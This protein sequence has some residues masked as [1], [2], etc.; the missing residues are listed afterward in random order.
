MLQPDL[1][2][3][4]Q[5][6]PA[7]SRL[8]AT[9]VRI[10]RFSGQPPPCMPF[11]RG[12]SS[13]DSASTTARCG[14]EEAARSRFPPKSARQQT[15]IILDSGGKRSRHEHPRGR[16]ANRNDRKGSPKPSG[17]PSVR[18]RILLVSNLSCQFPSDSPSFR[19]DLTA[20]GG[21]EPGDGRSRVRRTAPEASATACRGAYLRHASTSRRSDNRL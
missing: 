13:V 11:G 2:E 6:L 5:R 14:R 19:S 21:G 16:V 4:H 18:R 8:G 15:D 1:R 9:A 20:E 17:G 12:R 10:H 7:S 3:R